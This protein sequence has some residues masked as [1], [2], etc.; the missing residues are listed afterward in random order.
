ML[1]IGLAAAAFDQLRRVRLS[2]CLLPAAVIGWLIFASLLILD[3][4]R[5]FW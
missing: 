3:E 2:A 4:T 1:T 5:W